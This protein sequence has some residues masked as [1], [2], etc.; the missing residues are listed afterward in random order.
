ME[1]SSTALTGAAGGRE[2]ANG[3]HAPQAIAPRAV[4]VAPQEGDIRPPFF[5]SMGRQG[6]VSAAASVGPERCP[7]GTRTPRTPLLGCR[8]GRPLGNVPPGRSGPLKRWTKL[9]LVSTQLER[10][11]PPLGHARRR[12]VQSGHGRLERGKWTNHPENPGN[13]PF[14]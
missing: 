5:G 11:D 7:P 1:Q 6:L 9:L 12:L 14:L 8:L 10:R 13:K 2:A 4:S 3:A